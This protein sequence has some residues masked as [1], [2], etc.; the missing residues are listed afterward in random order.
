VAWLELMLQ[1]N[2]LTILFAHTAQ[3][4]VTLRHLEIVASLNPG[5]PIVPVTFTPADAQASVR[6]LPLE[7]SFDAAL[8]EPRFSGQNR[9][10]GTDC[11][12]YAWYVHART[13][14]TTAERY[15]FMEWD[16]LYRVPMR[17]FY[18]EVWDCDVACAE[19]YFLD[20]H[21]HWNWFSEVSRL[22]KEL[23]QHAAGIVPLAGTL[24]ADRVVKSITK[25]SIPLNVFCDLRL[26][27]LVRACGFD[28]IRL[29]YEKA[30]NI[31]W[32]ANSFFPVATPAYHPVKTLRNDLI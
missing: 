11:M 6:R 1:M 17:E 19:C 2:D 21:W 27:T 9:W 5:V 24:L 10:A 29:P 7:G 8:L 31:T 22:P 25:G 13:A 4:E 28:I 16:M 18:A 3:D 30:R 20:R 23:H 15:V 14:A 26:G 12:I 32:K